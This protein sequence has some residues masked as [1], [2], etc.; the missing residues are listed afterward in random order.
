MGSQTTNHQ[1]YNTMNTKVKL[2]EDYK[3]SPFPFWARLKEDGRIVIFFSETNGTCVSE[4]K[5]MP[6]HTPEHYEKWTD[7]LNSHEWEILPKGAE[8]TITV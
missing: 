1:Q 4:S 7:C 6:T 8:I 3:N 2:P 5:D